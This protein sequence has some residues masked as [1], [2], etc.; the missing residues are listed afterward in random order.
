MG[1][2]ACNMR[3][4]ARAL[5]LRKHTFKVAAV[6]NTAAWGG[7]QI[8]ACGDAHTAAWGGARIGATKLHGVMRT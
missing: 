2:A 8:A 4:G 6:A 5:H 3:E 1:H 7:A